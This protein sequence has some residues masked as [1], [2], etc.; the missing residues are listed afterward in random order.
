MLKKK[1][2]STREAILILW[3]N[4]YKLLRTTKSSHNIYSNGVHIIS[5]PVQ[6]KSV[7]KMMFARIIKENDLTV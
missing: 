2:Y 5:I 6:N 4:G 3:K 1:E 7:N